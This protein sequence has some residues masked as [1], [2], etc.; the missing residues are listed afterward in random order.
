MEFLC[1]PVLDLRGFYVRCQS[2]IFP[3][4]A[5]KPLQLLISIDSK[6]QTG[7]IIPSSQALWMIDAMNE[8]LLMENSHMHSSLGAVVVT[9]AV[10]QFFVQ[11]DLL[12]GL[13]EDLNFSE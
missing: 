6:P 5:S 2:S 12:A 11:H 1:Y 7:N 4:D 10:M 9:T 13:L 3:I 8:L